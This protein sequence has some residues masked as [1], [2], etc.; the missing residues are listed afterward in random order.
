MAPWPAPFHSD[1]FTS[2]LIYLFIYL[3]SR[4]VKNKYRGR[5][6]TSKQ[7]R[8]NLQPDLGYENQTKFG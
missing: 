6:S 2:V 1:R 3:L 4:D 7:M 8:W 5:K